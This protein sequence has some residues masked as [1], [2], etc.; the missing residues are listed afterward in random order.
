MTR[1]VHFAQHLEALLLAAL[2]LDAA[3]HVEDVST[4]TGSSDGPG[5]AETTSSSTSAGSNV[6]ATGADT[7]DSTTGPGPSDTTGGPP[8]SCT[9]IVEAGE[10]MPFAAPNQNYAPLSFM[11]DGLDTNEICPCASASITAGTVDSIT[12]EH[13]D[14]WPTDPARAPLVVFHHGNIQSAT[15]YDFSALAAAGFVVLNVETGAG[16]GGDAAFGVSCALEFAQSALEVEAGTTWE[17]AM[18]CNLVLSGGSLGADIVGGILAGERPD[19]LEYTLRPYDLRAGV[20]LG[21]ALRPGSPSGGPVPTLIVTSATDADIADGT[22]PI[23]RYD[24]SPL[25]A[26]FSATEVPRAMV[27]TWGTDHNAF[28]GGSSIAPETGHA[29]LDGT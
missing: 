29:V 7:T 28:G 14:G 22:E 11:L 6:D 13:P 3:C 17:D 16:L 20:L 18:D 19:N 10:C 15:L 2:L 24:R 1:S 12:V 25:E 8:E 26:E 23:T 4:L 9:V 5:S 21:P 27:Y